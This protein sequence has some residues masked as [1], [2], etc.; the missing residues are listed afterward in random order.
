MADYRRTRYDLQDT[1]A[2]TGAD[3]PMKTDATT[4]G[5]SDLI[6]PGKSRTIRAVLFDKDGT[7]VDFQRT[8]GPSTQHVMRTLAN[9]NEAAYERLVKVSG[10]VDAEQRFLPDSVIIREP[11][12]VY[13]ALW[14][15][16]LERSAEPD[17]FSEIDRLFLD[18]TIA[19]LTPIGDPRNVLSSL[20]ARGY[21]LGIITNDAEVPARA[22]ARKLGIENYL[23]FIAGY[24]SG[25]GA[26]PD[27]EP[28]L[29][30][31]NAIGVDPSEVAVVGD[32]VHDLAA[33]RAAGAIA[34]AVLTGPAPSGTLAA[35]ADGLF[36][37]IAEFSDWLHRREAIAAQ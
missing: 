34:I 28:V 18:A 36:P 14:A 16:A 12:H 13:G 27:P 8:W 6:H 31:A 20:A 22:H 32:T 1:I 19:N 9:G 15:A 33:A 4:A 29:A 35:H 23:E 7:L 5:Q 17:F 3:D 24:D 26:K 10:F 37:S 11:T 2:W 25:F 21:R 30:F